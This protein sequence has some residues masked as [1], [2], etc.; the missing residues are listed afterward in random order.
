[1]NENEIKERLLELVPEVN[2]SDLLKAGKLAFHQQKI[3]TGNMSVYLTHGIG[4]IYVQPSS[5]GCNVSLSGQVIQREMYPFM[6]KLLGRDCDGFAQRNRK[7]GKEDQP[8]WRT[9]DFGKVEEAIRFY[10][11]NFSG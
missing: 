8:F 6:Q 1:M 2:A 4:R 7:K 9:Q 5:L 3:A 10:V 11:S